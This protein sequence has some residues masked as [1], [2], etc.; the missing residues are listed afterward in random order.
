MINSTGRWSILSL[1]YYVNLRIMKAPSPCISMPTASGPFP[2]TPWAFSTKEQPWL[3]SYNS[4]K[5]P[6]PSFCL[7]TPGQNEEPRI[8]SMSPIAVARDPCTWAITWL[9]G[10][11]LAKLDQKWKSWDWNQASDMQCVCSKWWPNF[12]A[13]SLSLRMNFYLKTWLQQ[14]LQLS[15][16]VEEAKRKEDHHILL[17]R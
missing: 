11:I 7:S 12:C 4:K 8:Q 6:T 17:I 1:V 3:W 2:Q 10:F 16:D 15:L 14:F 9:P 5:S 13:T